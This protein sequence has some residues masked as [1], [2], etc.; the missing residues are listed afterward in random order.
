M[1][2]AYTKRGKPFVVELP[3]SDDF[4]N[5]CL[6]CRHKPDFEYRHGIGRGFCKKT[7]TGKKF[8]GNGD[9]AEAIY[10]DGF[11]NVT[12]GAFPRKSHCRHYLKGEICLPCGGS[13][14]L[15]DGINDEGH[16]CYHCNGTGY[17]N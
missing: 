10:V 4:S 14:E 8:K 9:D 15:Y 13:G 16:E 1:G 2:Y 5:E 3:N 17:A 6:T 12:D 7:N 11:G